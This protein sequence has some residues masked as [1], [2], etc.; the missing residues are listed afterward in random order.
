MLSIPGQRQGLSV[1][2][3]PVEPTK[4]QSTPPPTNSSLEDDGLYTGD[5]LQLFPAIATGTIDLIFADPP[6]NIGYDYDIYDDC[7]DTGA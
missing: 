3:N 4:S 2:V 5:C 7:R 6:F 1:N